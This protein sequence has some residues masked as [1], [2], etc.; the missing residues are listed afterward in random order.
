MKRWSKRV[1]VAIAKAASR[2]VAFEAACLSESLMERQDEAMLRKPE[3]EDT[4]MDDD[5]QAALNDIGYNAD[6]YISNQ[7][8]RHDYSFTCFSVVRLIC[9]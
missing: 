4:G 7:A 8:T 6:L 2:R 1:S 3:G 5:K 9:G